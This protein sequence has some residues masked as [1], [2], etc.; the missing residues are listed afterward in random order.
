M[1]IRL[2]DTARPNNF[3]EGEQQGTFPV[4]YAED[5]WFADGTRLSEKTFGGDSI[6]KDELPLAGTTQLGK[7][8]QYVGETGTYQNGCFYQCKYSEQS[9]WFWSPIPVVE[10][11]ITYRES[12]SFGEFPIGTVIVYSGTPEW[13][14]KV[15]HIYKYDSDKPLKLYRFT[16]LRDGVNVQY[17]LTTD[18]CEVGDAVFFSNSSTMYTYVKSI[19]GS[20]VTF[21]NDLVITNFAYADVITTITY[22]GWF[23]IGDAGKSYNTPK[24]M[25]VS[26]SPANAGES[27][28]TDVTNSFELLKI[29]ANAMYA[30]IDDSRI[31]TPYIGHIVAYTK[32]ESE[33][34]NIGVASYIATACWG[35]NTHPYIR[36]RI[37]ADTG[38]VY[39][40]FRSQDGTFNLVDFTVDALH[41]NARVNTNVRSFITSTQVFT[42]TASK[43]GF[44][45]AYMHKSGS[46]YTA[47][48]FVNGVSVDQLSCFS[49]DSSGTTLPWI[50]N[51]G[52]DM[53]LSAFVNEGD[54][55]KI[56]S[57]EGGSASID[58]WY[59][60][61]TVLQYKA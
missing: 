14:M 23:D 57:D 35:A 18:K 34:P 21:G 60:Y 39:G 11:G 44:L 30:D 27:F 1:A 32:D 48:L 37:F 55:I 9:G 25:N 10:K 46:G 41:Y 38:K 24:Y 29:I 20:T 5:I 17:Y 33:Q 61:A 54:I 15:G 31:L 53:T 12:Y 56:D 16:G 3:I 47:R 8:Y 7:I 49:E 13:G 36:M 43:T 42:F 52:I 22:T 59:L 4:A 26:N 6:Q 45:K 58:S 19:S 2:A 28:Y 40:F 50:A 51:G